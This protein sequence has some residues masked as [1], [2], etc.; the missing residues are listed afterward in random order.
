MLRSPLSPNPVCRLA[1]KARAT[2]RAWTRRFCATLTLTPATLTL[3]LTL[4]LTFT[5][6]SAEPLGA[7]EPESPYAASIERLDPFDTS[8]LYFGVANVLRSHYA[9]NFTDANTWAAV[10][11]LRFDGTLHLPQGSLPF[12][13]FKKKPDRTKVVLR[14][15]KRHQV[16]MA[17]D[18]EQAWQLNT[19]Q[20]P[21]ASRMPE[22]EAR[23]F[24]RDATTGGHLIYP[25]I[26]GKT[27]E[28]LGTTLIGDERAYELRITLPD[29]QVIRSFLD[30]ISFAEVQQI[31]LN[32]VSGDEEVTRHSN[33]R[34]VEGIRIPFTSTLFVEGEQV[35]QTRLDEVRINQGVTSWMFHR[36]PTTEEAAP[37]DAPASDGSNPLDD[38]ATGTPNPKAP[39]SFFD[40]ELE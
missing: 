6:G 20:S 11:S 27:I 18:G 35:H 22:D 24:I 16:V 21:I 14:A 32:N 7:A 12:S 29:G 17:Y 39:P 2:I 28:L 38:L 15:G 33:F 19:R 13:A 9:R 25:G 31:T 10:E 26:E 37:A 36:P 3:T 4:T 40:I 23:N 1:P 8:G 34:I 5:L 30:M